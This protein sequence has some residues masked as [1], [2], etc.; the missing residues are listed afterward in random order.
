[1]IVE[2]VGRREEHGEREVRERERREKGE[3]KRG[4]RE[5]GVPRKARSFFSARGVG[6]RDI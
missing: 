3:E 5:K 1:M 4:E 2:K 6:V